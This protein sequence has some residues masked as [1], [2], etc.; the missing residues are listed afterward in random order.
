ML[1]GSP[2][3]ISIVSNS[4]DV[5][6]SPSTAGQVPVLTASP[7]ELDLTF[8]Q[9]TVLDPSTLGGIQVVGAGSDGTLNTGDDVPVQPG[10]IGLGTTPNE[11]VLRFSQTLDDGLYGINILGKG[12]TALADTNSPPDLFSSGNPLQPNLQVDFQIDTPPQVVSVVPQ[13]VTF[14]PTKGQ[15]SQAANEIDVYFNKGIEPLP[16][17]INQLDPALFQLIYTSGTANT[18]DD[19]SFRP[20]SVSFDSSTNMAKLLFSQPLSQLLPAN[21]TQGSFRLRIGNDEV[22]SGTVNGNNVTN[23]MTPT[24]VAIPEPGSTFGDSQQPSLAPYEAGTLDNDPHQVL[25]TTLG[26]TNVSAGLAYPGGN[27]GPGVQVTPYEAPIDFSESPLTA[28]P[29]PGT[30]QTFTYNFPSIYGSTA[31]SSQL[32]NVITSQQENLAREIFQLW[33]NYLGVQFQEVSNE[34]LGAADFGIVTGVV[35]AINPTAPASLSAL[36]G[37][38]TLATTLNDGFDGKPEYLAIMN[39]QIFSTESLYGGPWFTAAMQQIGRLMG[40]GVNTQDPAGTVMGTGGSDP[41]TGGAPEPVYPTNADILHGQYIYRPQSDNVDM[42]KFTVNSAGTFNAETIAQR[43]TFNTITIPATSAAGPVGTGVVDGSTFTINDGTTSITFEFDADG[44]Q[45]TVGDTNVAI[46]YN[47]TDTAAQVAADVVSAIN[48]AATNAGLNVDA[49]ADG[50]VV[51]LAGPATVTT[52]ATQGGV[53]YANQPSDLNTVLTLYNQTN[54]IQ[55]PSSGGAGVVD[56]STFTI[57]DGVH[58]PVVFEFVQGGRTANDN[59]VHINYSTTDTANVIAS[60]IANAINNN[61]KTSGLNASAVVQFSQVVINGPLTVTPN[62]SQGGVTFTVSRQVISSNDDY[63]GT[64]SFVNMQLSPGVYYLAV[65]STGNTQFNPNVGGSGSG[66]TTQGPYDLKLDFTPNPLRN[67]TDTT[68]T[69]LQGNS[70]GTSGGAYDFWFN[71]GNTIFVDKTPPGG[72]S[73]TP[74]GSL[75]APYTSI[76]TALQVASDRIIAPAGN[77]AYTLPNGQ[78]EQLDGQTFV[79]NDGFDPPVTFEF[80]ANGRTLGINDGNTPVA[81]NTTDTPAQ[82]A[83]EIASAINNSATPLQVTAVVHSDSNGTFYVDLVSQSNP[84][85]PVTGSS[86]DTSGAPS[87]LSATKLVRILGDTGA[88][89]SLGVPAAT[90][91]G[92]S[93]TASQIVSA[94]QTFQVTAGTVSST[95]EFFDGDSLEV[96][97]TSGAS[98]TDGSKFTITQGSSSVTFEFALNGRTLLDGNTPISYK[99][100]DA[101]ATLAAEI[102]QAIN[103]AVAAKKFGTTPPISAS[104]S[105]VGPDGKQVIS[106][107]SNS[108]TSYSVNVSGL[109]LKSSPATRMAIAAGATAVHYSPSDSPI[110][111]AQEMAAAINASPLAQPAGGDVRA[112]VSSSVQTYTNGSAWFVT[113]S[114]VGTLTINAQGASAQTGALPTTGLIAVS[115]AQP[116]EIG[117]SQFG[118]TPLADGATMNV[119]QGVTVMVDAGAVFKLEGA[120]I[121]VGVN[122]PGIDRSDSA[123][124]VLGTPTSSVFFTSFHDDSIGTTTD[125]VTSASPGDWGGIVFGQNAD[126]EQ[127]GIFLDSVNDARLTYGGGS[128]VVDGIQ[129]NYTPIYLV[130]SRPAITNNTILLSHNA[131]ISADPNSFAETIFGSPADTSVNLPP[132]VQTA[133]SASTTGGTLA[134]GTYYYVLTAVGPNGETAASGEVSITVTGATSSVTLNWNSVAG[135]TGYKIYRGLAPGAENVLV[136][137]VTTASATS[138]VDNG[139]EIATGQSPPTGQVYIT[140]YER[141][142]PDIAG[143]TLAITQPGAQLLNAPAGNQII[144][145]ETFI[146][147]TPGTPSSGSPTVGV[148]NIFEFVNKRATS[149][150]VAGQLLA[151]GHYAV[152]FDPGAPASGNFAAIPPETPA[153]IATEIANAITAAKLGVTA[154]VVP[155]N[156]SQVSIS[157][158]SGLTPST[159]SS[160][161]APTGAQLTDGETF[162]VT[163]LSTGVQTTFEFD[164]NGSVAS[165]HVAVTFTTRDTATT[166]ASEMAAAIDTANI[167]VSAIAA[168]NQVLLSGATHFFFNQ[169]SL[170]GNTITI[171]AAAGNTITDG[172]T[173]QI[174]DSTTRTTTTFVYRLST[175]KTAVPSGEIP[176]IYSTTDAAATV[177]A[178]TAAAINGAGLEVS[179]VVSGTSISLIEEVTGV[180]ASPLSVQSNVLANVINGLLV[181]TEDPTTQSAETLSVAAR[182]TATDIPY[183]LSDNLILQGNPG[184][185]LDGTARI[186]GRLDIDPGVT[187][188]LGNARIETDMGAN[189]IAEGTASEPIV[190]TSLHDNTYGGGGT[191]ATDGVAQSTAAPPTQATPGDWAG[192]YFAPTSRGSLDHTLVSY[193]GGNS[194]VQGNLATFDAIE[195]HQATVRIADS[196]IENNASGLA[197]VSRGDLLGNDAAAIY[198]LGAQPVIVNNVFE[199]NQGATISIDANSLTSAI[200]PDPGRSTGPVNAF[201]QF[202]NNAGPLV[203]LNEIGNVSTNTGAING[204]LVRGGTLDTASVW[205]DTDIVHVVESQIQATDVDGRGGL[206]LESSPSAS[207]VVKF[208]GASAGLTATGTP[209]DITDRVGGSVQILGMPNYPVILTALSDETAG[210]GLT[211]TGLPNVL[212]DNGAAAVQTGQALLPTVPYVANGTTVS[213]DVATNVVGHFQATPGPGGE[214]GTSTGFDL[215]VTAQGQ[216]QLL[217]NQD[218][219]FEYENYVGVG[220][221]NAVA[222]ANTTITQ[223]PTLIGQDIVQ[224]QG[225]FAG[226]NGTVNWTVTTSFKP[227]TTQMVN[228]VTFNSSAALGALQFINYLDE[229]VPPAPDDDLLYIQGTPGQPGFQV[230][231][232]DGPQR[233]GLSQSGVYQAGSQLVNATYQ[234]WAADSF[235]NLEQNI[236]NRTQTYSVAGNINTTDLPPMTDPQLGKVYGPAD[237]TTAFAWSIN[238][239]STS[240]TITT[241][242]NEVSAPP[243]PPGGQWQGITLNQFSNDTNIATINESE[244]AYTGGVGTNDTPS[245]AQNLGTLATTTLGGSDTQR[246]GFTVNGVVSPN[247]S[248]DV[249]TYTFQAQPGTQVWMNLGNTAPGLDTVLELV[250]ANGTVLARSDNALNEANSPSL[251]AQ[252]LP[253]NIAQPLADGTLLGGNYDPNNP[254]LSNTTYDPNSLTFPSLFNQFSSNPLDAGFRVTLPGNPN[255]ATLSNYYVRV[256]SKDTNATGL[257]QFVPGKGTSSGV[258][259]LQIRLQE[260]EQYAGSTIQ[261][262][263]IRFATNGITVQGLP[264]DSP[265]VGDAGQQPTPTTTDASQPAA[266]QTSPLSTAQDLGN[267]LST[268]QGAINVAGNVGTSTQVTWYKFEADYNLLDAIQGLNAGNKSVA[269][270]FDVNYADGI[271]RPDTTLAVYDSTGKLIY[272]GRGSNVPDDQASNAPNAQDSLSY[273]SYGQLDPYVGSVQMPAGAGAGNPQ[274]YYVAISSSA[275]LPAALNAAYQA[276]TTNGLVRLEPVDS[277]NRIA[278]DHIGA[279]GGETAQPASSLTP[280]FNGNVSDQSTFNPAAPVTPSSADLQ[281]IQSLNTSAVP[282]TLGNDVLFVDQGGSTGHLQTVNPFTGV[283]VTDIGQT[284]GS[285]GGFGDIAMRNDGLLYGITLG[286]PGATTDANSGQYDQISTGNAATTTVGNDGI[287]TYDLN[288]TTVTQQNAGVQVD[289]L[290]FLQSGTTRELFAVGSYVGGPGAAGFSNG[291]YQLDP[292]TGAVINPLPNPPI[293]GGNPAPRLLNPS[294]VGPGEVI[295]GMADVNG[296]LYAVTNE[297]GLYIINNPTG[298]ASVQFVAKITTTGGNGVTFTSLTNG[299]ADTNINP[300]NPSLGTYAN[301]LFA[302]DSNGKL[303]AFNTSG[304]LQPVFSGGASSVSLGVTNVTG[305]A[306]STLDYNLWHVTDARADDAGHGINSAPDD[307]R[308]T[309]STN[310]P[311]AGN[312][313]YYFGLENPNGAGVIDTGANTTLQ[314]GAA[315]YATNSSVYGTYNLPGGALGS[316]QTNSFSLANYNA[317]DLPTLYFNYFLN[318]GQS[319]TGFKSSARVMISTDGGQTWTEVATNDPTRVAYN[320]ATDPNALAAGTTAARQNSQG[321]EL[322]GFDSSSALQP[323]TTVQG[324]PAIDP[325]QQV[326]QLFDGSGQWLQSRID[327]SNYAG[328]SNLMLRFDFSTAGSMN[329]GLPGDKFGAFNNPT[330]G[331]NNGFEGFYV[332]DVTVGLAG[333]GEMVTGDTA[334][335][336]YF[337]TPT[338][339]NVN[340]PTQ[341]LTGPY[342][343]DIRTGTPYAVTADPNQPDIDLVNSYNINDRLTDGFT[344]IAPAGSALAN[345]Q[346]FQVNDGVHVVTFEF[347]TSSGTLPDGNTGVPFQ[348]SSSAANVAQAIA[349][350][351][352]ANT[353]LTGV[354]AT[355]TAG[356]RVDFFGVVNVSTSNSVTGSLAVSVANPTITES[357]AGDSTTVTISRVNFAPSAL[358]SAVT[359]HLTAT[360]VVGGLA[361]SNVVLSANGSTSQGGLLNV[362][363][364]AGATSVVVTVTGVE[365]QDLNGDELADGPQKVDITA[366]AAGYGSSSNTLDVEDDA[367]V[368]PTLTVAIQSPTSHTIVENQ[369][370]GAATGIVTRNSPDNVPLV[371]TLTSLDTASATVPATVTIPAGA[372]SATF[373][374]NAVDDDILRQQPVNVTI[375]ASAANFASGNTSIAV[376]DDGDSTQ[377]AQGTPLWTAQGPNPV[378][379]GQETNLTG[380]GGLQDPISGAVQK[381]LVDPADPTGNTLFIATVNGGIWETTNA[382]S[383]NGPTWTP[384][385]DNMPS[386]SIGDVEF[387]VTNGTFQTMIAGVGDFSSLNAVGANAPAGGKLAGLMTSTNGGQTWSML[388][389]SAAS[390]ATPVGQ[391]IT[392]VAERGA[393]IMAAANAAFGNTG[394][395]LR[396]TDGGVTFTLVSTLANSGLPA[397]P[398]TSL[399]ADPVDPNRFYVAV[400]GTNGGIFTSD[401]AGATWS[402]ITPTGLR[403]TLNANGTNDVIKIADSGKAVDI[404]YEKFNSTN[405]QTTLSSIYQSPVTNISSA[406]WVQ[407]DL[408][409]T[410]DNGIVEGLN[411]VGGGYISIAADPTNPTVVYVGGDQQPFPNNG[412]GAA[413]PTG[414]IFR[415]DSSRP[416]GSQWTFITDNNAAGTAPPAHSRS[417][418]FDGSQLLETDDGG[419]YALSNPSTTG[420]STPSGSWSSLVGNLDVTEI[421]NVAY[422]SNTQT[423]IAGAVSDAGVPEQNTTGSTAW[424]DFSQGEGGD[425]AVDNINSPPGLTESVRY[426]SS[427]FMQNFQVTTYDS[428]GNIVTRTSPPLLVNNLQPLSQFDTNLPRNTTFVLNSQTGTPGWMVI[429]GGNSVYESFDGGRTLTPLGGGGAGPN[430]LSGAAM[431]YGGVSGGVS[432]PYVLWVGVGNTVLLRT[433]QNGTLN[434]TNYTGAAVRSLTINPVNW[435]NAFLVDSAG[436]VWETVNA[437]QTYQDISGNL[438]NGAS[439]LTANLH[440]IAFVPGNATNNLIYVGAQDGVYEM[441][442]SNPGSWSRYGALM[443]DVPVYS[444]QYVPSDQLLVAGTLGRGAYT[445]SAIGAAGDLAVSLNQTTVSDNGGT[446]TGTIT[447]TGTFGNLAVTLVSSDPAIV[448][449]TTWTIQDGQ[450]SVNFSVPANELLDAAGNQ[451]AFSRETVFLTPQAG[452]LNPISGFVDV[453]DSLAPA[454]S[455]SLSTNLLD[456][457]AGVT[458]ITGTVTRN[459][460]TDQPL[461]VWLVSSDP[462]V[463]V[464]QKVTIPAGQSSVTFAVTNVDQFAND[465]QP[466][467]VIITAAADNFEGLGIPGD[468]GVVSDTLTV[469][470]AKH[471]QAYDRQGDNDIV[472]EQGQIV[473]MDNRISNSLDFGIVLT[474]A[475]RSSGG[476]PYPGVPLNLKQPDVVNASGP[477]SLLGFGVAPGATVTNNLL[478][479]NAQGGI[480]ISGDPDTGNVAAAVVPIARVLNNTIYGGSTPTGVGVQVSQHA[481]PTIL[482]NIFANL[483]TGVSVDS[484]SS[485]T[486]LEASVYQND[487]T[488]LTGTVSNNGDVNGISLSP[489]A[490]LFTD[491][492]TNDFYLAPGSAAIDSGIS[493]LPARSYLTSVTN[494]IGIPA[495]PTNAPA[496]DL[497]GQLRAA[498]PESNPNGTGSSLYVDRGAIERIDFSGP[499]STLVNPVDNSANDLDPTLNVVHEIGSPLNNFAIQLSDPNGSGIDPSTVTSSKFALYRNGTKLTE[500]IDY[501]FEFDTNT[502][503]V[504]FVPATGVWATGNQ[505]TIF[506]DNGVQFDAFGSGTQGG[507]KDL[508]GNN[509]QPNRGNGSVD[510]G[511]TQYDIL[512]QSSTG[513]APTVGVPPLQNVPENGVIPTSLTFSSLSTTPNPVTIYD[514]DAPNDT[515]TVKLITANGTLSV[516]GLSGNGTISSTPSMTFADGGTVSV[517]GSGTASLTLVGS[518]PDVNMVLSGAAAQ[519]GEPAIAGLTFVPTF[520]YRGAASI[521][522]S[523]TDAQLGNGGLTGTGVVNIDVTPVNQPPSV[524]VPTA[525]TVS[526]NPTS[527]LVFSAANGNAITITDPDGGTGVETVSISTLNTAGVATGTVALSQTTNLTFVQGNG[528]AASTMVFSG[529]LSAINAALNG[530][531]FV[532]A[533]NFTGQAVINFSVNDNG[534]GLGPVSGGSGNVL[535]PSEI[536]TGK[537]VITVTPVN[538]PPFALPI[539][540]QTLQESSSVQTITFDLSPYIG[541]P[542]ESNTPPEAPPTITITGN[543]NSSLLS[544]TVNGNILTVTVAA[545]GSGTATLTL[546][547]TD[548]NVGS[549]HPI[550][551]TTVTYIVNKVL[552]PPSVGP[553]EY[554][555][556]PYNKGQ[557]VVALDV[558]D[559]KGLLSTTTPHNGVPVEVVLTQVP[560]H[561][562]LAYN[563]SNGAFAYT[564][565][566]DFNGRDSFTVRIQ[567]TTSPAGTP[568]PSTFLTVYLDSPTSAQNA[569]WVTSMYT[570]VLNRT[571]PPSGAEVTFW[572]DELQPQPDANGVTPVA[573]TRE[574]VAANFVTSTERRSDVIASLYEQ[575]LGRAVDQPG[576]DYWLQVWADNN[577]PELVQAGII[578]SQEYYITAGGTPDAWVTKLYENLLNRAPDPAGLA[579]WA[580]YIQSHSLSSVV[581]GFVTSDEYRG[582]LLSGIP[583]D[584]NNPGWYEQYLHRPVDAAGEAYWVQQMDAGYAQEQILEGILASQEYYNLVNGMG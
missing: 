154:S 468:N 43:T 324:Q 336:T 3:L 501:F 218:F 514:I 384:L 198:V 192:L 561:G 6:Y 162:V 150:V 381:V 139:S 338:S 524:N 256:Y 467:N 277:V 353:T 511:F 163:N 528:T 472:P 519:S 380:P 409:T 193:A 203:R 450:T 73:A 508:A 390:P 187:V 59:D 491:P 182:W 397:G 391:N 412:E 211:P 567:D 489:T 19:T 26:S 207:L 355:V 10:Y 371:V 202:G 583:G 128:V 560:D 522:V 574:Q 510:P 531:Q 22:V 414:R 345:G 30:V 95:F 47:S 485:S 437:G 278:E 292:N 21:A 39:S 405:N 451:V 258:Y 475:G 35:Q 538:Q 142:G 322:P 299:P 49:S 191:F 64:D 264:V 151:D 311:E 55:V 401:N 200:V 584:P 344:I 134:A 350:A 58:P 307:S 66:G 483:A 457:N 325:R 228:Q 146:V 69:P 171:T 85:T 480:S 337:T 374:I 60:D 385:T 238:G 351:V 281:Q 348:G 29:T 226:Q 495:S 230:F 63:F 500:G 462:R 99:S 479:D 214:L 493:Q 316:L 5:V 506:I 20:S 314:P 575:Y 243:A 558:T 406:T 403:P 556:T 435:R 456:P 293:T 446:I 396:S 28:P 54:V 407:M 512:L 173:L 504:S 92:A 165:G 263:D 284:A 339:P 303:W 178:E 317:G 553:L 220:T 4:G 530:L 487:G 296:L 272:L 83:Q 367:G 518:V 233:V 273:G 438:T 436:H 262:A 125:T 67:L 225:N 53:T 415:G 121:S 328:A 236:I 428:Q 81:F 466:H 224:S 248:G 282:F 302:A 392:G 97:A 312:L 50:N 38:S 448:P 341:I 117:T 194:T 89:N 48:G 477:A 7:R 8:N 84:N 544:A 235:D 520:D 548:N 452:G 275:A 516:A 362:L 145:G 416:S 429:G 423:L 147:T 370:A 488:N 279:Q 306:F 440:S 72:S 209:L 471:V 285:G 427:A 358:G 294:G 484:T 155:T 377:V 550:A 402:D 42:Y 143:N 546:Q 417:L 476:N 424:T 33:S 454:L 421:E 164:S 386:L 265:L 186:S 346:T 18:N 342:Q 439:A 269:A 473:L 61:V 112:T 123:L 398:V 498:D 271:S 127:Q 453:T 105:G 481:S 86:I 17:T 213:N 343:L 77:A 378:A 217:V 266:S 254:S 363:I 201:T 219:A 25:E 268:N 393:V 103:G 364:P 160:F 354:H 366:T 410:T 111:L 79:V 91:G 102:A 172:T 56:G 458:A 329:Q 327:L 205:D 153:Q 130:G 231:T 295:T 12:S 1:S 432:N 40:L 461:T 418:V 183:V 144:A 253:G 394:G 106:I 540:N 152:L 270:I 554:V 581:Y 499:I 41:A 360:D 31:N 469:D 210:A 274:T 529:T 93:L 422:D 318:S 555:Y 532:P 212:T 426:T 539:P 249:D 51:S 568:T 517:Q 578:G 573:M 88:D 259:Q 131:A 326:Q 459:T 310:Q 559:S 222:L 551:T 267:L 250:S 115:N 373:P 570:N 321:S 425:V 283:K 563:P 190:F 513:D 32:Q 579:Y 503:I 319:T 399:I 70:D 515:V 261:D 359:V 234:G 521:S 52:S 2:T 431:A 161:T 376:R 564:P 158:A 149:G 80:A 90:T 323:A 189:L 320:A 141:A 177:A 305:L 223:Q 300:S 496:Y 184:G 545:Y 140:D 136:G 332:D 411:P 445:A 547:A 357:G 470:A 133:P 543:S 107:G 490:P 334:D 549:V 288:G 379:D 502:N 45:F 286:P 562:S 37:P 78:T 16:S 132:P 333:R 257:A 129:A 577:G 449:S 347:A 408:P 251:L 441:Q 443:P 74:N 76:A 315:N 301:D 176:I 260:T 94:G 135:A 509:L 464:P 13:P 527:P 304:V 356:N 308:N 486:V 455:I 216:T 494:P 65:T 244:P 124:Q 245:T 375:V 298:P 179:A 156:T 75:T 442:T 57:N 419:I 62:G 580:N 101:P 36:A 9:G 122:A 206:T 82:V 137:D 252:E 541:D 126:M 576:L 557:P 388:T 434:A 330:R 280:L 180:F 309:E 204:M 170:A 148:N 109:Q 104:L 255:S 168:T 565:D 569:N 113:L 478:V 110:T 290:A 87:L 276:G 185:Q 11:V 297:G 159:P 181:R 246:L 199:N 98:I 395:L 571:T 352:N 465:G 340:V 166:V 174:V 27:Y 196:T 114:G 387:D 138:F 497:Y 400:L 240:S 169:S 227:G 241:F 492:A 383:A 229:D 536:G 572:V 197:S 433:T 349:N 526:E 444:L 413:G 331:Q 369:G 365:Q 372:D 507:I 447:R 96:T 474:A 24:T 247:F 71:V 44:R 34:T 208:N 535:G 232:I 188:K 505:Y 566:A 237:Q 289:A 23:N 313:S 420:L 430:A 361:S 175:D 291:L 221:N 368:I 525:Q 15:L 533:N 242:L 195:I 382:L 116:Y 482:N 108:S 537:V 582:D 534:N 120:N 335:T 460:P 157:G 215:G 389:P 463:T 552:F 68:G 404:A 46:A 100:T 542:D 14:D 167:G 523:V 118:G 239:T 119:P 287:L